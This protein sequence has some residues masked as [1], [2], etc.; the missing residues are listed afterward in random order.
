MKSSR[1]SVCQREVDGNAESLLKGQHTNFIC[2][3][4]LWALAEGGQNGL[5]KLEKSL[6]L[7]TREKTEGSTTKTPMLSYSPCCRSH[8]SQAE[9]ISPSGIS[10]RESNSPTHRNYSASLCGA[11]A[12]LLITA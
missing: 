10:L 1:V 8:L 12:R 11:K 7:V 6:G 4:L 3:H 9:H 2:S 5:E